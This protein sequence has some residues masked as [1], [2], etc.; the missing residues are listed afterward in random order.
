VFFAL[1]QIVTRLIVALTTTVFSVYM[2]FCGTLDVHPTMPAEQA[3]AH[4]RELWDPPKDI[5]AQDMEYGP[6]GPDFAPKDDKPF[7]FDHPKTHG[8]SPGYTVKDEEG[9]EWSVKFG[10]EAHVEVVLS[11]VL[12]ALG[13][14]QPPVYHL[15]HFK[16]TDDTGT[17]D[18]GNARF[19]PKIKELKEMGDWAWQ[20]NP[21]VGT[22][23]YQGLLVIL[24]MFNSSD[25]K[26]VNNSL[27]EYTPKHDDP[28]TWYVVRDLG[29]ALGETA[30]LTPRRNDPE[31]FARHKFITGIHDDFVEFNYQGWHKE[32]IR[33][34]I[35]TADVVW[36]ADLLGKLTDTQWDEAF[37]SAGYEPEPAQAFIKVLKERIEEGRHIG[38]SV[39]S[40]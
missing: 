30:K 12:S 20:Q 36:A 19:R 14:H 31:L 27:Y 18:Q 29:T 16:I 7:I 13:Y 15:A 39:S 38:A 8:V 21:F 25:L 32:L 1:H 2:P 11:R 28:Q 26:N 24:L 9:R 6:W 35:T 3:Q 22:K 40:R 17:H 5:A 33:N 37:K 34:R 4:M 10:D 23:P